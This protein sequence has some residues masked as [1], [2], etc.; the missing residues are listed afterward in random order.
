MA[1][2]PDQPKDDKERI[3]EFCRDFEKV[4]SN[5]Q[6]MDSFWQDVANI[7]APSRDFYNQWHTGEK[8][9]I[10]I[11]DST[12]MYSCEQL[13]SGL[14]SM[15][16]NPW[17]DWF[18]LT[19]ANKSAKLSKAAS[20][21]LDA[22][23]AAVDH[24]FRSP[25]N[26][27]HSNIHEVYQ[28]ICA[29]GN[30]CMYVGFENNGFKF[31]A[32]PLSSCYIM[33]ND[34]GVVDTIFRY[35]KMQAIKAQKLFLQNTP[36]KMMEIADKKPMEEVTILHVV[37]PRKERD[38]QT[39]NAANKPF[40][41]MYIWIEQKTK[42]LESGYDSFPYMFA[43]LER[44]SG[45]E[46]GFGP[47][48]SAYHDAKM[49]NRVKE[50][51]LRGAAKM[52]DPPILVP[53]GS[54]IGALSINPGGKIVYNPR[55]GNTIQ[56]LQNNANPEFAYQFLAS[57]QAQIRE[58]FYVDWL[59]MPDR[60]QMTATE[61]LDRRD[62]R[63]RM[64]SPMLSRLNSDFVGPMIM[65]MLS[66]MITYGKVPP[67][68]DD[69]AQVGIDVE[70]LSPIAQAQRMAETD[71]IIRT[72]GAATAIAQNDPLAMQNFDIDEAVRHVA[73]DINRVPAKIMRDPDAVQGIRQDAQEQAQLAA[74]AEINETQSKVAKNTT[75]AVKA[76][77][78]V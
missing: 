47:G 37:R 59:N 13:A 48:M 51:M 9:N 62:E 19:S 20:V 7:I 35:S 73:V 36:E 44:R 14:H 56:P 77:S 34:D 72:F 65:R 32:R 30:A 8:R 54:I 64:L 1:Y 76:L 71:N 25:R 22:A 4:K 10:R 5:R 17:L 38:P 43:R 67:M 24:E 15:L 78:Q 41:S 2:N 27:F 57:I 52:V 50:V 26:Q 63:F 68:P 69:L 21:W 16:T 61:V 3:E 12:A 53:N 18:R 66:L 33:E 11:Y 70:Y 75:S 23:T 60:P 31:R 28:D 46:Y 39:P 6:P 42:I 49:I 45:E 40:L 29:F 58:H 55:G 74:A